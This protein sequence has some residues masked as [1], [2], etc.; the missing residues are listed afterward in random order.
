MG[1]LSGRAKPSCKGILVPQQ[2]LRA[3]DD[4]IV[5]KY[6]EGEQSLWR[7]NCLVYAG[8]VVI[9]DRVKQP[10]T[11]TTKKQPSLKRKETDVAHLR[12][13]IG[14]LEAE[15]HRRKS[16]KRPTP[17]Q[18]RNIRL[19]HAERRGLREL[20]VSLE[21]FKAKLGVRAS[22]LRRF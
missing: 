15:I 2:L 14:W 20:E 21:T 1:D 7:L 8:A 16:G 13:Q 17:R 10:F 19:L 12:R 5:E 6:D 3:V 18:W 11:R 22:Q 9:S 4:L